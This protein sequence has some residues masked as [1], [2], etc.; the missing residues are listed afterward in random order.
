MKPVVLRGERIVLRPLRI[1]DATVLVKYVNDPELTKYLTMTPP[2]SLMQEEDYV[3]R[4]IQGWKSGSDLDWAITLDGKLIGVVVLHHVDKKDMN[5]ELGIWIVREYQGK[6][7]GYESAKLA[8]N[9]A[10]SRLRMNR[11]YYYLMA[12]NVMSKKLIEKLGGKYEGTQRETTRKGGV[13][14]DSCTYGILKREWKE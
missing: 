13:F 11:I 1:S 4:T 3:K 5:T 2:L 14:Y 12:S 10:F 9:F 8:I 6:G 7:I